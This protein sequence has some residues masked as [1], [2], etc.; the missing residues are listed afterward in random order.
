MN[1]ISNELIPSHPPIQTPIIVDSHVHALPAR[2]MD[3]YRAWL[4]ETRPT[5]EGPPHLWASSAFEQPDE[6][7]KALDAYEIMTGLITFSSNAPAAMHASA[8]AYKTN[9]PAM[10]RSVN[11]ELMS[12][13]RAS[14]GRLQTTAFI[15]PRFGEASLVELE[16]VVQQ[17]GIQA[18]SM[19]TAYRGPGQPLRFL[20][21]PSFFP[22]LEHAA[23]L[24]V[25]V[26]IHTSGRFNTFADMGDA[27]L[28]ELATT[29]LTGGLS[30]L[31]E[32]TLCLARLVVSGVFD[33]LPDLRLVFGQLGGL[34]PFV[35]GR[36]DVIYELVIAAAK[37]SADGSLEEKHVSAIFRRLRDYAGHVY[38][39]TASMD[40]AAIL[41]ALQSL[42][43]DRILYGSDFP[44]TPARL[45]RQGGLDILRSLPVSQD[46]KDAIMGK[47]ALALFSRS[48]LET[49]KGASR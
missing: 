41:C 36:F 32:S 11:D 42:G 30:M 12:W 3:A 8:V 14:N 22:I 17:E 49:E 19:L 43:P 40:Q 20:D 35:L 9:G 39:D 28:P 18:I 33:R 44:V 48:H 21:H 1:S 23:T 24:K 2:V 45:G 5:S 6:Q 46:V 29:Y 4:I 27:P 13:A 26:Y 25:P 34:L 15:E 37:S 10:V 7:V 38:V 47:N 31:I 16:R